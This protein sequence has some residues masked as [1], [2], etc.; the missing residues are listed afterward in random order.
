MVA[1]RWL[2]SWF[3]DAWL[4]EL[5]LH[6]AQQ[7]GILLTVL[8]VLKCTLTMVTP[9][10]QQRD[11]RRRG[12]REGGR[13]GQKREGRGRDKHMPNFWYPSLWPTDQRF[14]NASGEHLTELSAV[15][16]ALDYCSDAR[17][18]HSL[19]WPPACLPTL[20]ARPHTSHDDTP[21]LKRSAT[22]TMQWPLTMHEDNRPSHPSP[23]QPRHPP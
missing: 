1:P 8:L 19:T 9:P 10:E 6:V 2:Q 11:E 20:I 13:E 18:H 4:P 3:A 5:L 23:H 22:T 21:C 16:T 15:S 7:G 14:P 12:G 17:C